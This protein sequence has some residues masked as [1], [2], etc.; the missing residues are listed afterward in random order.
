MSGPTFSIS[1]STDDELSVG[2]G[3]TFQSEKG[4]VATTLDAR[5][6]RDVSKADK[7]QDLGRDY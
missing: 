5:M 4:F 7:L 6:R 2:K 1:M 3:E